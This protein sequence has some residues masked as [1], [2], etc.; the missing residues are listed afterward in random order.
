MSGVSPW[1]KNA[2]QLG[3][4]PNSFI[5][6]GSFMLFS[7]MFGESLKITHCNLM[8]IQ[9]QFI[10]F[11][12]F[13]NYADL[14]NYV[15]MTIHIYHCVITYVIRVTFMC[16]ALVRLLSLF[17]IGH[18]SHVSAFTARD[19]HWAVLEWM[20][21]CMTLQIFLCKIREHFTRQCH[22]SGLAHLTGFYMRKFKNTD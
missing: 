9:F 14:A 8:L 19:L 6:Y 16:T 13:G 1:H 10:R 15:K 7:Y 22:A 12:Y 21:I 11:G 17:F 5:L 2:C 4:K 20:C 18:R 3:K